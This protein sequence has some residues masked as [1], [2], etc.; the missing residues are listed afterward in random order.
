MLRRLMKFHIVLAFCAL[1]AA[2]AAA[3]PSDV[4][5]DPGVELGKQAVIGLLRA[6]QPEADTGANSETGST[7]AN[8][9]EQEKT[10]F[11]AVAEMVLVTLGVGMLAAMIGGC[12]LCMRKQQPQEDEAETDAT[13][14]E[15]AAAPAKAA[16]SCG[17]PFAPGGADDHDTTT[18]LMD[19]LQALSAKLQPEIPRL[20]QLVQERATEVGE[21]AKAFVCLELEDV[22]KSLR[23]VMAEDEAELMLE[24]NATVDANLPP[25]SVILSGSMSPIIMSTALLNHTLQ[26]FMLFLPVAVLCVAAMINDHGAQI[27]VIPTLKIWLWVGGTLSILLCLTHGAMAAR[28][29][30]GQRAISKKAEEL[31][32]LMETGPPDVAVPAPS[33]QEVFMRGSIL[34]QSAA[35]LHHEIQTSIFY[36]I[37]GACTLMWLPCTFWIACI[38]IFW[39]F[40]PGVIAFHPKVAAAHVADT[41]LCEATWTVFAGRVT[42]LLASLF[43]LVHSLQVFGWILETLVHSKKVSD[44]ILRG[45][46]ALDN[47]TAMGFPYAEIMVRAFVL[48][49]DRDFLRSKLS[50]VSAEQTMLEQEREELLRHV[51]VLE[52]RVHEKDRCIRALQRTAEERGGV[53][54]EAQVSYLEQNGIVDMDTWK[55]QGSTLINKAHEDA[56][57]YKKALVERTSTEDS[58]LQQMVAQLNTLL[59]QVQQQVNAGLQSASGRLAPSGVQ[60]LRG[61]SDR[62]GEQR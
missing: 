45:A 32:A 15:P 20:K 17:M 12:V 42:V 26:F 16:R 14:G 48:H 11:R 39:T 59:E 49:G 36:N 57:M 38:I 62:S 54:H 7:G 24:W 27:C 19:G 18:Q 22:A 60:A 21:N 2:Y 30:L 29:Y 52:G 53:G 56:A 5:H 61:S 35:H 34:L 6:R 43:W 47:S 23:Q 33:S 1:C 9:Q 8:L 10:W 3:L 55:Q 28:I 58:E 40:Y 41:D 50:V 25:M 13:A 37:N 46:Q 51:D 44:R 4:Y 31:D